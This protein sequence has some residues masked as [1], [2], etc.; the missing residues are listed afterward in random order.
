M[1]YQISPSI[2]GVT[3]K[4]QLPV[5][6]TLHDYHLVCANN[7]S[8]HHGKICEDCIKGSRFSILKNKCYNDNFKASL[9]AFGACVSRD[10]LGLYNNR[11][12]RWDQSFNF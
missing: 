9:L 7:N 4:L 11:I 8:F 1:F 10:M 2:L 6:E 5:I 12:N 3:E